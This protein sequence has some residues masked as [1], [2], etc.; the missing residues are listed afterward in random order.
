[1]STMY[2][3]SSTFY[4]GL[5]STLP[6]PS[7]EGVSEPSSGN[8]SRV[9]IS[10]FTTPSNG[11]VRNSS[12]ISFPLSSDVWFPPDAMLRYW[13]VFDGAQSGANILSAG[14]IS[15]PQSVMANTIVVIPASTLSITLSDSPSG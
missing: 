5:S 9:R 6:K 13:I 11:V 10:G 4:V 7:G 15:S 12:A 14:S 3:N 1:M 8:Y 2:S